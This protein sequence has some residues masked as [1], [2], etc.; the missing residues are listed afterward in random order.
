MINILNL[1]KSYRTE[2]IETHALKNIS[3]QVSEGEFVALTGPSGSGKSTLLN[4]LGTLENFDQGDYLLDGKSLKGLSDT[5]LS[6]IRNEKI[7]F[8]FQGFNLIKDYSISDNIELPLRYR[9]FSA[10]E[11]KRR[12]ERVL[13]LVGLAARRDYYPSQL[14]GGQQQRVA[15]ARAIAGEPRILLA[16]E[17]TGNLDSLMARQVM[18]L[19]AEINKQGCTILMVTH[20]PD[21]ARRADRQVQIIDGHL[22]DSVMYEPLSQAI[23]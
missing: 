16:D 13:D 7:G 9:G 22:S 8:I 3:L 18:E 12:V 14:S 1:S 19:L 4:V 6:K 5:D 11:R 20:D 15:I 23:A 21:Q 2:L 10:A 17:P